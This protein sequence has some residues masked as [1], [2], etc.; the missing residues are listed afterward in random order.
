MSDQALAVDPLE[1]AAG[2]IDDTPEEVLDENGEPIVAEEV[3]PDEVVEETD[4]PKKDDTVKVKLSLPDGEKE[5]T[6]DEL[7]SGY[8]Q[9]A[10]YTRKTQE[11]SQREREVTQALSQRLT[12][13]QQVTQQA[14]ADADVLVNYA[15]SVF[16]PDQMAQLAA[17]DPAKWATETQRM[18]GIAQAKQMLTQR[19]E[20]LRQAQEQQMQESAAQ[21]KQAAW[22]ALSAANIDKPALEKIYSESAKLYGLSQSDLDGI[23]DARAVLI[24]RDALAYRNGQSKAKEL[25][26]KTT[27][28]VKAAPMPQA[29]ASNADAGKNRDA[30]KR[31]MSGKGSLRDLSNLI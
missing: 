30:I 26:S 17:Q 18:Q 25:I 13:S 12:Q 24:M 14:L 20:Q 16:S 11:L 1:S 10:D 7:K 9:Q 8:M 23:M 3:D 4:E 15:L 28:Q 29:R 22:T 6:L 31:I 21:A 5:V 2:L 27:A 19:S